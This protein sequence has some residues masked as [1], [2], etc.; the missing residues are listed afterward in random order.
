MSR[1]EAYLM[2]G[3]SFVM[4]FA[5]IANG[6]AELGTLTPVVF[7]VGSVL[8]L[9]A[10]SS[11]LAGI[12]LAEKLGRAKVEGDA[13]IGYLMKQTNRLEYFVLVGLMLPFSE[14]VILRGIS[15]QYLAIM[16]PDK[17][18]W[19]ILSLAFG[20]FHGGG[21]MRRINCVI[22]GCLYGLPILLGYPLWTAII[23]H[24][25]HNVSLFVIRILTR[26]D[27]S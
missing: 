27:A 17:V 20:V 3:F 14:E 24:M 21:P 19:L 11:T 22:D 5:S 13:E 9:C 16:L 26:R 4:S 10:F 25:I 8:G 15:W 2:V 23:A 12:A 6:Y 7:I 1:R 18:V